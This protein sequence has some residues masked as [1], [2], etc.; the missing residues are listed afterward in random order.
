METE[1]DED[2]MDQAILSG[3]TV[4]W[5]VA[6]KWIFLINNALIIVLRNKTYVEH[7]FLVIISKVVALA[8]RTFSTNRELS[9]V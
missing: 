5:G 2:R 4:W 9:L 6:N 3:L 1:L 8:K 7:D